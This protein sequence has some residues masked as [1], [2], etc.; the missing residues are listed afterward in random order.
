MCL[1]LNT[2]HHLNRFNP[3]HALDLN[4]TLNNYGAI[5]DK[6]RIDIFGLFGLSLFLLKLKIET[7]NAVAK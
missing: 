2:Y 1:P 4:L 7:E 3:L 6:A 5:D